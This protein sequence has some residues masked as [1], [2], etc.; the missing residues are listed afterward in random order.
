MESKQILK[1]LENI[2]K[3]ILEDENLTI[4]EDMVTANIQGWDSLA[5]INLIGEIEK[6]FNIQISVGEIVV[7]KSISDMIKLVQTKL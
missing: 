7:L 1:E 5:Q 3:F 6:H 2:F 4:N